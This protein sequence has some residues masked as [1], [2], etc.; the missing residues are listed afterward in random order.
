MKKN[1]QQSVNKVLEEIAQLLTER[2][3]TRPIT[4]MAQPITGHDLLL[5]GT[6]MVENKPVEPERTYYIQVPQTHHINHLKGLKKYYKQ[7]N[8]DGILNY[9][10]YY[11]N[12]EGYEKI[13]Q[14]LTLAQSHDKQLKNVTQK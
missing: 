14:L 12:K 7:S 9:C 1:K 13:R 8:I 2:H 4:Y 3:P 10:H 11:L 5:S 6:T